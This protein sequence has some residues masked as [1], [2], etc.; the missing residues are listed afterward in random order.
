M[1]EKKFAVAPLVREHISN[2][3][4]NKFDYSTA[5]QRKSDILNFMELNKDKLPKDY[6]IA[7]VRSSHDPILK[8]LLKQ[9][10]ID[11]S[12]FERQSKGQNKLKYKS[13]MNKANI[14]PKPQKGKND[15]T[16]QANAPPN[17]NQPMP[18]APIQAYSTEAVSATFSAL[19]LT[20]KVAVPQLEDLTED[21]KKALGEMWQPAFN[22]YLQNEKLAVIGIPILSTLGLFIPKILAGRKK[23]KILKSKEEGLLR[24]KEIDEKNALKEKQIKEEKES[25]GVT[26]TE[27]LTKEIPKIG[28]VKADLVLPKED[29]DQN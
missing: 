11:T 23:A 18:E 21:E 14:D 10:N 20:I 19:F 4:K 13:D 29:I 8:Q 12:N 25:R 24:Q 2:Q 26:Q 9:N 6:T 27:T 1:A 15:E 17:L 5:T 16:P 28:E 7:K 3:I 22:L